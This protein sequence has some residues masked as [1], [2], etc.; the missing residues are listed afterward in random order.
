M[1]IVPVFKQDGSVHICGDHKVTVNRALKSEVYP[2]SPL[3]RIDEL[4]TALSG[5]EF[6]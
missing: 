4:F 3:S 1:S 2:L 5:R 6:L